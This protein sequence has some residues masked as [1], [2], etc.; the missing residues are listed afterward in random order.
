MS[1]RLAACGSCLRGSCGAWCK[2]ARS[3]RGL[4]AKRKLSDRARQAVRV[5]IAP[6]DAGSCHLVRLEAGLVS[7]CPGK[8]ARLGGSERENDEA[9]AEPT[10]RTLL[11][12]VHCLS[13][14]VG[15]GSPCRY[16][17]AGETERWNASRGHLRGVHC[18]ALSGQTAM[19]NSL[20]RPVLRVVRRLSPSHGAAS[21]RRRLMDVGRG[22]FPTLPRAEGAT[23]FGAQPARRAR[24]KVA[25][26]THGGGG[27]MGESDPA[28]AS[29]PG[30][31]QAPR[32][33]RRWGCWDL[34]GRGKIALKPGSRAVVA[35]VN[36]TACSVLDLGAR[37][38][39]FT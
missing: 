24:R 2:T 39:L 10:F 22:C 25:W 19:S 27:G 18:D 26:Q 21:R 34:Q 32:R 23:H 8:R 4:T 38:L 36:A 9:A 37:L 7:T 30:G 5:G 11:S 31:T 14:V 35:R 15:R 29:V 3:P 28:K 1:G 12:G 20:E 33:V 17:H 13:L 6:H 16:W